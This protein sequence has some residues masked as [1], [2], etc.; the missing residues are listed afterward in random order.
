MTDGFSVLPMR[1]Q[2]GFRLLPIKM[3]RDFLETIISSVGSSIFT[4]SAKSPMDSLT[5]DHYGE[6]GQMIGE[7]IEPIDPGTC[8]PRR[9][10]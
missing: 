8:A 1:K 6:I 4:T 7:L 2:D 3:R 9:K 10:T 5:T